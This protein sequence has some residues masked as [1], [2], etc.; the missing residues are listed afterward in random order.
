MID[1]RLPANERPEEPHRVRMGQPGAG[2]LPCSLELGE[3][4]DDAGVLHALLDLL[5]AHPRHAL[6]VEAE[7]HLAVALAL[8]QHG[9]P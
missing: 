3:V 2:V 1:L 4:A 9:D 6:D 7:Q 5:V 8:L